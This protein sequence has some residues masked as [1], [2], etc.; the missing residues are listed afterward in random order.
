ML[1]PEKVNEL[2]LCLKE[3]TLYR[4][5]IDIFKPPPLLQKIETQSIKTFILTFIIW[6]PTA[7]WLS[8]NNFEIWIFI[9]FLITFLILILSF[10]TQ[11]W[12]IFY[13]V[14]RPVWRHRNRP[15]APLLPYLE[16]DMQK[17][18][19]ALR[20]LCEF[21]KA[22][23][24]YGLLQYRH[25]WKTFDNKLTSIIGTFQ[26]ISLLQALATVSFAVITSSKYDI[27]FFF[28][29]A[30]FLLG[31]LLFYL[32][33]LTLRDHRPHQVIELLEYAIKHVEE[34]MA[35]EAKAMVLGKA[36]E[37]QEAAPPVMAS[38]AS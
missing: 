32:I 1:Q 3:M 22:T 31:L 14:M 13:T 34:A 24:E 23:L 16:Y 19:G 10:I 7:G 33:S 17:D 28:F 27:D 4:R 6:L 11:T 2:F 37:P 9:L 35:L 36:E 20:R 30:L 38:V 26:Q 12:I 18:M 8:F 29:V 25:H 15:F 5:D 21:S